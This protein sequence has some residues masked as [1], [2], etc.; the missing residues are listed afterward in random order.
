MDKSATSRD[1]LHDTYIVTLL[2][3]PGRERAGHNRLAYAGVGS[4]NE[5]PARAALTHLVQHDVRV[6]K[7]LG[8]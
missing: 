8:K 7:R 6:L 1:W 4:R 2:A 5:D 3:A